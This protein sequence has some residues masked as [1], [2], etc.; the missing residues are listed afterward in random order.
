[1]KGTHCGLVDFPYFCAR[2]FPS[3]KRASRAWRFQPDLLTATVALTHP[4]PLIRHY[5]RERG[6]GR[7]ITTQRARPL[8]GL[9]VTAPTDPQPHTT[10]ANENERLRGGGGRCLRS[11]GCR[12]EQKRFSQRQRKTD[13]IS[14]TPLEGF[15]VNLSTRLGALATGGT[16]PHSAAAENTSA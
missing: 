1:M 9:L 2:A 3:Q 16:C 6:D 7:D 10:Q 8:P 4:D 14:Y 15:L 12:F 11:R 13:P 5:L